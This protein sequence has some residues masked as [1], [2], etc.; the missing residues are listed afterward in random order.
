MCPLTGRTARE[1]GVL[2]PGDGREAR[3]RP[4]GRRGRVG[5]GGRP[6]GRARA[7]PATADTRALDEGDARA[8]GRRPSS[9]PSRARLSTWLSPGTSMP[10]RKAG[11]S[12]GTRRRHSVA[13]RRWARQP[14]RVLVGEQVVEAGAV[15][16][17]ERDRHRAGGVVADGAPAGALQR[18]GEGG[19]QAGALEEE[20]GER[21]LAELRL[22]DGASM[23][24]ATQ[25][26]PSRPGSRRDDRHIMTVA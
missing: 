9:A 10:P 25:E 4:P 12:A 22:G 16:R 21:G 3:A 15:G 23:P 8:R 2:E 6:P 7:R 26:A 5:G 17:I 20:R 19:P 14:E 18:G 13:L 24:A 11:L 1:P